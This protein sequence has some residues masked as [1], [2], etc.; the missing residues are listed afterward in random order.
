M[1]RIG[2]S[3]QVVLLL[4]EQIER[5]GKSKRGARDA[6]TARTGVPEPMA[7][8]RALAAREGL[9]DDDVKRALVCGLLTQQLGDAIANDPAFQAIANDVIRIIGATPEGRDLLDR[10]LLQLSSEPPI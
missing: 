6:A 7:R 3:D 10:A 4:Q 5:L 1:T 9:S 8:V 2:T